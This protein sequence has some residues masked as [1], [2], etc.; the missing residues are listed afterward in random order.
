MFKEETTSKR[1]K[2]EIKSKWK[3]R[4]PWTYAVKD[5]NVIHKIKCLWCVKFKRKTPIAKE[6]SKTLQFIGLNIHAR[7]E[8]HKFSLQLLEGESKHSTL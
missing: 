3:T 2:R 1:P 7:S 8:T 6:G 5:S 4:F